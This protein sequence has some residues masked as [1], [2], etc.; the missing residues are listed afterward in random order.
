MGIAFPENGFIKAI[1][2][3]STLLKTGK[4]GEGNEYIIPV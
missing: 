2:L 4:R 3:H 1:V